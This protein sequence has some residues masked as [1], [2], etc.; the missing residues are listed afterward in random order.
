MK[1][2]VVGLGYV[3]LVTSA[4]L[5]EHFN[6]VTGIDIDKNKIERLLEGYPPLYEHNLKEYLVRNKSRLTFSW[7]YNDLSGCDAVFVCTPTPT[8]N[9]RIDTKHVEGSCRA[10]AKVSPDSAIIIKSTVTPGTASKIRES[11]G[12]TVIS[13]PEF[14]REGSAIM[15]TEKPDRIIIGGDKD[16]I[17][18]TVWAFTG[19]PVLKTT[20]ENAELIKYAS[21]AFL[22]TKISFINEI[23]NLCETIPGADVEIVATGMGLDKRIA[24]YFLR[25]GIGYGGSCFPK[26]T[27]AL[28]GFAEDKGVDL[29]IVRATIDVNNSRINHAI[30]MIKE[31]VEKMGIKKL[32][33]LGLAFKNGTDDVRESRAIDLI[34]GLISSGI[35]VTYYDPV[36]T[37]DIRGAELSRSIGE[38]VG[39]CDAIVIASEWNEFKELQNMNVTKP[40]FDLKRLL[41]MNYFKHYRGIGLWHE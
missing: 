37:Q 29:K 38:C 8:V 39:S 2:G 24:P 7:D 17:C 30:E 36:V 3:G 40:V 12:L 28:L 31:D 11:T 22:A 41:E 35:E 20:N 1:I 4:V 14:T 5:A 19:S 34:K 32:C 27:Q 16:D 10:I 15:D 23:A 26:D 6:S 21:N 9:S 33:V 18:E 25:A 13:N